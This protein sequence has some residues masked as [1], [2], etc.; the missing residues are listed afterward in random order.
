M[1]IDEALK[2]LS[3]N[4]LVFTEFGLQTIPVD[5]AHITTFGVFFDAEND[6][7]KEASILGLLKPKNDKMKIEVSYATPSF[8]ITYEETYYF[9]D[10]FEEALKV[11]KALQILNKYVSSN[12]LEI[13]F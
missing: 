8:M 13:V 6:I 2:I 12:S 9:R 10:T 1:T 4:T 3:I 5:F 7:H 11:I